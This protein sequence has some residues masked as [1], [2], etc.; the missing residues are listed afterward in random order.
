MKPI[1]FCR[2]HKSVP[3]MISLDTKLFLLGVVSVEHKASRGVDRLVRHSQAVGVR[4]LIL[5]H[6]PVATALLLPVL[7]LVT[8]L[9]FL[10]RFL[11]AGHHSAPA[12]DKFPAIP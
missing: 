9:I 10:N 11:V 7:T 1:R 2:I 4:L 3:P 5:I 12:S 8:L 6:Q